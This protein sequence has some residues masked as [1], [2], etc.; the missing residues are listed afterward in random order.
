VRGEGYGF[1]GRIE[2]VKLGKVGLV[3]KLNPSSQVEAAP[4]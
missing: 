3:H 4:G 2:L 1:I